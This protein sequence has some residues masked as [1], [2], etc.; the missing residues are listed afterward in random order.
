MLH[1]NLNRRGGGEATMLWV[2]RLAAAAADVDLCLLLDS[3]E[4][5]PRD[6]AAV[7]GRVDTVGFPPRPEWRS[8]PRF[9]A[10]AASL[11]A[12]TRERRADACIAWSYPAAFRMAISLAGA[13]VACAWVCNLEIAPDR[14]RWLL[15]SAAVRLI[16]A[17]G[18]RV[19]CPSHAVAGELIQLGCSPSRVR[20]IR[21]AVD[22]G[23]F[24]AAGSLDD[25]CRA[26][27]RCRHGI[28]DADL[29]VA[30]VARVD[31]LKNHALLLRA[32]RAARDAGARVALVCVGEVAP[33]DRAYASELG[34]LA[35]ALGVE[36]QVRWVGHQHDVAPW[37]AAADAAA[38]PSLSE[39]GPAV[40]VEAAAAGVALLASSIP[41]HRELVTEGENGLL[42]DPHDVA[43]CARALVRLARH[44][45]E[46]RRLGARARSRARVR[47][48]A[49]SVIEA[50]QSLLGE[51]LPSTGVAR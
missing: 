15:R 18:A 26:A 30:C 48:G 49:E 33:G 37:L 40:L 8:A 11:R 1:E 34:A 2:S 14:A 24:V 35:C 7:F 43:G 16:A 12:L 29:V 19:V 21:P 41:S 23:R 44:P 45:E 50:W 38:L 51:L 27:F 22:I 39:A 32:L 25:E 5:V 20:V 46:R 42:F 9:L 6:L 3:K 47:N 28:P 13:R 10:S 31:P 36:A 4:Q 17:T